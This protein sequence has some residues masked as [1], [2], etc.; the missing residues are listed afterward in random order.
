MYPK[1][2]V[3]TIYKKYLDLS[4]FSSSLPDVTKK[5]TLEH[6]NFA[7]NVVDEWNHCMDIGGGTGHYLAPLATKFKQATLV[8]VADEKEHAGLIQKLPNIKIFHQYIEKYQSPEKVDF[9]LLADLFEHIPDIT[10]FVRQLA[11]IQTDTGVVYIMTPNAL[12]CGPAP[13]SALHHTRHP[14]GHIKQYTSQEIITLM[15]S[16]GYELI[17]RLYEEAPLRQFTKRIVYALSRRDKQWQSLFLY[18]FIRPLYL[19]IAL[20]LFKLLEIIT[21]QSE[22]KHRHN[23]LTTKTQDLL[24]KKSRHSFPTS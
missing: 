22:K 21:Y 8:E 24:F 10:R 9:I 3:Y 1:H 16:V 6:L 18:S 2:D 5:I 23:E 19:C 4:I 17:L 13:E 15:G 14:H 20:P 12:Y 7:I 11:D